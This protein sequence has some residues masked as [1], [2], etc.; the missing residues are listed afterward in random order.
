VIVHPYP[1]PE[2]PA[3]SP[4]AATGE[5]TAIDILSRTLWAEAHD[6]SVR[7]KEAIA[8]TVINRTRL[9]LSRYGRDWWG[10]TI[11]EA[12]LGSDHFP[13]WRRD[14]KWGEALLWARQ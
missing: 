13:C 8:A 1:L 2:D 11:P 14:S 3:R 10:T 5:D 4:L 6:E 7:V 12:C 9:A